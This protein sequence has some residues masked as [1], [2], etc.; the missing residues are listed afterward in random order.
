VLGHDEIQH[1]IAEELQ[2][3]VRTPAVLSSPTAV[4]QCEV[5]DARV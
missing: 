3:F 4:A 1:G 5:G 2:S